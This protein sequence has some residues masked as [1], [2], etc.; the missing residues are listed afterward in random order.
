MKCLR[1]ITGSILVFILAVLL[2]V[3]VS[4]LFGVHYLAVLSGSMAPEIPQG[5]LAISVPTDA[6]DIEPG[7]VVSYVADENLT[8]TTHRVT[9]VDPANGTVTTKGDAN[10]VA[11]CP[12]LKGNVLGTVNITIPYLGYPVVFLSTTLGKIV[13]AV[14]LVALFLITLLFSGR[15]HQRTT[16]KQL[17]ISY[18][19]PADVTDER[20]NEI[21]SA[22]KRERGDSV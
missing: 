22:W 21:I 14:V 1:V 3:G 7:D 4:R 17:V 20:L 13:A 9:S 15:G 18:R 5:S 2:V 12:V 8:I 6:A 16:R 19:D 10:E 11:D